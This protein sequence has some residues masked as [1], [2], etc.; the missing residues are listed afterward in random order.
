MENEKY[1]ANA[2]KL[3]LKNGANTSGKRENVTKIRF[4]AFSVFF[5]FFRERADTQAP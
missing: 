3:T 4:W 5:A 1:S 2:E